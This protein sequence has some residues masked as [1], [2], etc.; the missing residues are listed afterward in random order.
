MKSDKE[1]DEQGLDVYLVK[2]GIGKCVG[3]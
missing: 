3:M 2:T 1:V